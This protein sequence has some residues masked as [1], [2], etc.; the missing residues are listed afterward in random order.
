MTPERLAD[1]N[2]LLSSLNSLQRIADDAGWS[3]SVRR[4]RLWTRLA[5]LPHRGQL[6]PGKVDST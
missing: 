3:A 6:D 4:Y 2:D 1:R 5:L